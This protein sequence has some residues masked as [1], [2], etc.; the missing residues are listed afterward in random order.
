MSKR[1]QNTKPTSSATEVERRAWVRYPCD[2]QSVCQ[3]Y[4]QEKGEATWPAQVQDISAGGASLLMNRRFEPGAILSLELG[5]KADG[6]TRLPLVRVRHV[7]AGQKGR[8]VIG[9]QFLTQ[10]SDEELEEVRNH[11]PVKVET[12]PSAEANQTPAWYLRRILSLPS[13]NAGSGAHQTLRPPS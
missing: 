5:A 4:T 3:P 2:Q 7:K 11:V 1:P 6:Q 12:P 10:L 8:W 9:C 13:R